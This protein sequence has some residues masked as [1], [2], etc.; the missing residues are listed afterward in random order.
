LE[1]KGTTPY[2]NTRRRPFIVAGLGIPKPTG[3]GADKSLGSQGGSINDKNYTT[4]PKRIGCHP[5]GQPISKGECF[6]IDHL[7]GQARQEG[8]LLTETKAVVSDDPCPFDSFFPKQ[9][10]GRG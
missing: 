9:I 4:S 7:S 2:K 5:I 10:L 1:V 3:L 8:P 6:D